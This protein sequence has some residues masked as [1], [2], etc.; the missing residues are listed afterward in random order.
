MSGLPGRPF[1]RLYSQDLWAGLAFT[2]VGVAALVLG[3]DLT[4]DHVVPRRLGGRTSW[5]NVATACAP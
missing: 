3:R 5:E 2:L 1:S 4:F